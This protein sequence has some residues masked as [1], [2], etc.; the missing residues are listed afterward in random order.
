VRF[1]ARFHHHRQTSGNASRRGA[2][3]RTLLTGVAQ[4]H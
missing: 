3:N 4:E 1:T 2:V